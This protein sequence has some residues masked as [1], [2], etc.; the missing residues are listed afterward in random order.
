MT[1]TTFSRRT[2]LG[3][4]LAVLVALS[5]AMA[6]ARGCKSRGGPGGKRKNGKCPSWRK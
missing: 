6:E 5:P 3:G 1:K 4:L 2:A